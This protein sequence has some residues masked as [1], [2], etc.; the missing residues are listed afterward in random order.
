VHRDRERLTSL[1]QVEIRALGVQ[2][3][4]P[5]AKDSLGARI[6]GHKVHRRGGSFAALEREIRITLDQ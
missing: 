3:L 4:V 1:A 5:D 6:A 2:A